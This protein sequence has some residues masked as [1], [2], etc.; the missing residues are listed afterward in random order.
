MTPKSPE[1]RVALFPGSFNPFTTGHLSIVERGL[2]IFDRIIVGVGVNIAKADTD[3]AVRH[4]DEIRRCLA[5]MSDR[6]AV[7]QFSDLAVDAARRFGARFLLRGIRNSADFEYERNMADVNRRIGGI[8]TVML[9]TL[10]ELS[11][12][13]SS[14]V[15]ELA[16]FGRDV[17]E[18][19]PPQH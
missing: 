5:P 6:V 1:L 13:S 19:L 14:V 8:E 16:A 18:F 17:S 9:P 2:E 3:S 12:V 11:C 4:L 7:E 15:R 10:P